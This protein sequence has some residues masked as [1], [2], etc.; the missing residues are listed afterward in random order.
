VI[1]RVCAC[2]FLNPSHFLAIALGAERAFVGVDALSPISSHAERRGVAHRS[3]RRQKQRP[4][5]NNCLV[6]LLWI[7]KLQSPGCRQRSTYERRL[8]GQN[9]SYSQPTQRRMLTRIAAKTAMCDDNRIRAL[10]I[11]L[12]AAEAG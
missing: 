11:K 1:A 4:K 7:R 5:R 8:S 9:C 6:T 2:K 12:F 10:P 3:R